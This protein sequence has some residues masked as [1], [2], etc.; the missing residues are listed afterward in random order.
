[1]PDRPA[2]RRSASRARAWPP[3]D[4]I[5]RLFGDVVALC[6]ATAAPQDAEAGG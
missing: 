4:G 6:R 2:L 5:T 3:L 1:M